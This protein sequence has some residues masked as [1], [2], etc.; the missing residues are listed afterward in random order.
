MSPTRNTRST[1]SVPNESADPNTDSARFRFQ[2]EVNALKRKGGKGGRPMEDSCNWNY[3]PTR[4][5]YPISH[6]LDTSLS[7]NVTQG[8]NTNDEYGTE[9]NV[10]NDQY[11]YQMVNVH[12]MK[13]WMEEEF[14]C[15]CSLD[16]YLN[17]FLKYC[18]SVDN[19]MSC[20]QM[21]KLTRRWKASRKEEDK[22][23]LKVQ[24]IGLEAI[25]TVQ[26]PYCKSSSTIPNEKTKFHGSGYSGL[27]HSTE[28]CSWFATNVKLVLGTLA[29]GMGAS[30]VSCFLSFLGLPNLHSFSRTQH[31]KIEGLIGKTLRQVA[32]DSMTAALDMEVKM[33]L[34]FKNMEILDWRLTNIAIGLTFS[35]DMGWNKRSSGKT[36]DSLSGHAFFVGCHSRKIVLAKITSKQCS[37]C[38]KAEAK[39]KVPKVHECP[40][41]YSGS[42]KAME[43]DGALSLVKELDELS[44]SK[45]FV[46]A[47]V[48]DDDS[49]IRALI[50]H[51]DPK[52]RKNKGK[53]PDHIPEPKWL[54]DPSHR[55]RVVARAIFALVKLRMK[56]SECKN[57]DA[58]RFKRYFAYML[59]QGR[60][61]TLEDLMFRAKAV[62]EHLFNDHTYCDP[63]WCVPLRLSQDY[64]QDSNENIVDIAEDIMEPN[65]ENI[66]SNKDKYYRSKTEH[67][68]LYSQMKKAYEPYVTPERLKESLH[69]FD[70]QLNESLNNVVAKY[71]PKNRTYATSMSLSNRVMIVVG[72]HNM[73]H[74]NYWKKVFQ[75]IGIPMSSNLCENLKRL[76]S[77]KSNKRKYNCRKEVKSKRRKIQ[78]EKMQQQLVQ[79]V[80]DAK[81]GAIYRPGFVVEDVV[82]EEIKEKENA[83][84]TSN[85][86]LCR[87][88]GCH[89]K[90]HRTQGSK[91][92]A[93]HNCKTKLELRSAVDEKLRELYPS[94]YATQL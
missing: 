32:V 22:L 73:G 71:A 93:Y 31:K 61:G 66:D 64:E 39:G 46:E 74:Y 40:K 3:F 12:S 15:K 42:S 52:S 49:S 16:R 87:L 29:S 80:K 9:N 69:P 8:V 18:S 55:T 79:Q 60:D 38:S 48:T 23:I 19:Q 36:F 78:H 63:K 62:L 30:D 86:V 56:E 13:K 67:S 70:T 25:F 1:T 53:L 84:R 34:M 21:K 6:D 41:N 35:Y 24:N 2:R 83:L 68:E 27:S 5:P 89:G 88:Y 91:L 10:C 65:H 37:V 43:A 45:L 72:I 90:T 54:A 94:H 82:P 28:N 77:K 76:D 7:N 20:K 4:I 26:C 57:I 81:R 50:S 44:D 58:Q 11:S 59:K 75:V 92:C 47:F 51:F 85:K 14:V 33:T 17:S